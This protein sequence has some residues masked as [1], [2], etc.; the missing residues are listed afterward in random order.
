LIQRFTGVMTRAQKAKVELAQLEQKQ[1]QA[2]QDKPLPDDVRTA[3][4]GIDTQAKDFITA[5]QTKKTD[6]AEQ[7]LKSM[8]E[9]TDAIEKYLASLK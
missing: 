7:S 6:Q 9:A 4:D 8:E 1:K 5:Y 3:R 2:G